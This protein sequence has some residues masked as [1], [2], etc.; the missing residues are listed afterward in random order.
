V[1]PG[2]GDVVAVGVEVAIGDGTADK[3]VWA[4]GAGG[5]KGE[6]PGPMVA[7]IPRIQVAIQSFL[8]TEDRIADPLLI[9]SFFIGAKS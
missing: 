1:G 5:P 7:T 8:R 6:Q 4:E 2:V 3:G 9:D